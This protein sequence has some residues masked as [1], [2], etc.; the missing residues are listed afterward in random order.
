MRLD[1]ILGAGEWSA[2]KDF[3]TPTVFDVLPPRAAQRQVAELLGARLHPGEGRRVRDAVGFPGLRVVDDRAPPSERVESLD[4]EARR[5]RGDQ[6]LGLYF[7]QLL[8]RES[9]LL[10]LRAE[11]FRGDPPASLSWRPGWLYVR[12]DPAFLAPLRDLYGGYYTGD[13]PRFDSAIARLSLTPAKDVFLAHFG[14]GDQREVQFRRATF[15]QTFHDAF[16]ACRDAG[17]S[18]HGNFLA[19]GLYLATLYEHLERLDLPFD[20]RAAHVRAAS[21]LPTESR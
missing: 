16:V 14:G 2:L 15:V 19:L 17:V 3:L 12:W 10:D 9:A 4:V 13:D 8:H 1:S 6:V 18:L 11:R 5:R 7:H 21:P 20:V